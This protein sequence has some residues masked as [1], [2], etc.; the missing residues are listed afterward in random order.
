MAMMTNPLWKLRFNMGADGA[1]NPF[2]PPQA[3]TPGNTT[4]AATTPGLAPVTQPNAAS[5]GE[6]SRP[7][8]QGDTRLNREYTGD[9]FSWTPG[10]EIPD[11]SHQAKMKRWNEAGRPGN[12]DDLLP[13]ISAAE[14]IGGILGLAT[15]GPAGMATG[16]LAGGEYDDYSFTSDMAKR[17]GSEAQRN[18]SAW[19]RF[20]DDKSY[21][22]QGRDIIRGE[23]GAQYNPN[24]PGTSKPV[25]ASSKRQPG[26]QGPGQVK[27]KS[28]VVTSSKQQKER[29]RQDND[30]GGFARD[31]KSRQDTGGFGGPGGGAAY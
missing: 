31:R 15:G 14:I 10:K 9:F 18:T 20:W 25:A 1:Y 12:I 30:R 22:E 23:P 28:K 17:W 26:D 29:N 6:K 19:D 4:P 21:G 16:Y 5:R 13:S 7:D 11:Q 8:N 3:T 2:V 27:K 24:M